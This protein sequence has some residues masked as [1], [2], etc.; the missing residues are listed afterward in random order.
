MPTWIALLRGINVGGHHSIRM[1]DLRSVMDSMGLRK[2]QTYIASG[3]V[4]FDADDEEAQPLARR[5]RDEIEKSHGFG[6]HVFVLSAGQLRRA[7]DANPYPEAE[8]APKSLH[9]FFLAEP[10]EN[11]DFD[12]LEEA[13]SETEAYHLTDEVFYLHAPDGIG[14]SKLA[15]RIGRALRVDMT[16]RNWRTV[17]KLLEMVDGR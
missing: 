10:P 16:A 17:S 6:P 9:L 11:P 2:V 12:L 5:L 15:E 4:V 14:R 13:R 3:N 1:Q 8:A 7:V